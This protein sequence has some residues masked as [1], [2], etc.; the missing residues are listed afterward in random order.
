MKTFEVKETDNWLPA[1]FITFTDRIS[2]F[3]ELWI[4]KEEL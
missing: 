4:H 2:V 3:Y 1:Y